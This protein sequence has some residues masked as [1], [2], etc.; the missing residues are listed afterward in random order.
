MP[1][2]TPFTSRARLAL[3]VVAVG[4]SLSGLAVPAVAST[5]PYLIKD[6]N[7][8]GSSDPDEL[9]AMSGK[10]YF[11]AQGGGKGRELWTSDGTA[12][13]THRVK[14]IRPGPRGSS[15]SELTVVGGLLF[16]SADDG[17]HGQE[18]WV[19]DGTASGTRLVEDVHPG[20]G[21]SYP[22]ELVA[23]RGELWFLADGIWVS[24]GT[25]QG[26]HAL[27]SLPSGMSLDAAPAAYKG[28]IYFGLDLCGGDVCA[29]D[30][31]WR[32]DGTTAGTKQFH[33]EAD[34]IYP[35][36]IARTTS[37]LYWTDSDGLNVSNGTKASTQRLLSSRAFGLTRVGQTMFFGDRDLDDNGG[38]WITDGTAGGTKELAE[39]ESVPSRLA[40]VGGKVFFS[41]TGDE[42][43]PRALHSSNGTSQ[44]TEAVQGCCPD[45]AEP[46]F[47]AGVGGVAY[48]S[49]SDRS[50]CADGSCDDRE[51]WRSNGTDAGT[52]EVADIRPG[53]D[54]STP[55]FLVNVG[56]ALFFTADDGVHGRE[57]WRY[58]P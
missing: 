38:L 3:L 5:G 25:E 19:S 22:S 32:S 53:V 56:G 58:A 31:L 21:G 47:I 33:F 45:H 41:A 54:S 37:L 23:V 13:G 57:L 50:T 46:I 6:I 29:S 1:S 20:P 42:L 2:R 11:R 12:A 51:L 24:N 28:R 14:D 43:Q 49:A 10:L 55:Q 48:F 8:S 39:F 4:L 27:A 36:E 26:T 40:L 52:F 30:G 16:F 15:P 44:G 9:T 7:N 18:L 35:Q 17:A 34:H